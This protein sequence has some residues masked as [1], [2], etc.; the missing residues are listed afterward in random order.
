MQ[1]R[2]KWRTICRLL[3]SAINT[4]HTHP[5]ADNLAHKK[6]SNHIA[7]VCRM[8]QAPCVPITAIKPILL[9]RSGC[10]Q[11]LAAY[12][13][14]G[15]VQLHSVDAIS[16]RTRDWSARPIF[17]VYSAVRAAGCDDRSLPLCQN[18]SPTP[19]R[20]LSAARENRGHEHLLF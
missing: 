14:S 1:Q 10:K 7:I 19:R 18:E 6:R 15:R 2:E 12:M 13:V 16:F 8:R 3:C 11:T 4:Q 5:S 20:R 9:H 17:F